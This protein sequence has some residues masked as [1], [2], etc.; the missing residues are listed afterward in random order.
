MLV[1][2]LLHASFDIG[3]FDN[4]RLP[5]LTGPSAMAKLGFQVSCYTRRACISERL[6]DQAVSL[7]KS[8]ASRSFQH[9][10]NCFFLQIGK[11]YL[12]RRRLHLETSFGR[13]EAEGT[14]SSSAL[15]S[16]LHA[17]PLL[18]YLQPPPPSPV[19]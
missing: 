6:G 12:W 18:P 3:S 4:A 5:L 1:L 19:L 7:P 11:H 14:L 17:C 2:G 16:A 9:A 10:I 15:L 8:I 13:S